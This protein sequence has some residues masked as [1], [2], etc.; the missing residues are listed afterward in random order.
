MA[1]H[2]VFYM[3]KDVS[4][5]SGH[6]IHTIKFYLKIGLIQ[7]TGRSQETRFRFFGQET[8]DRLNHIRTLRK[9]HKSLSQIKLLLDGAGS[10][11]VVGGA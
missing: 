8:L 3:L 4:R 1:P 2:T 9:E 6:S 11:A 5:L 7:E 10:V